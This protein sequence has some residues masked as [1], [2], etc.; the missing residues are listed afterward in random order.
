MQNLKRIKARLNES[1]TFLKWYFLGLGSRDQKIPPGQITL[2]EQDIS[3]DLLIIQ[4][5]EGEGPDFIKVMPE[6]KEEIFIFYITPY[7]TWV[8][9]KINNN[10]EC[11]TIILYHPTFMEDII[12]AL[13][14]LLKRKISKFVLIIEYLSML[15][16]KKTGEDLDLSEKYRVH[17]KNYKRLLLALKQRQQYGNYSLVFID[18]E[19]NLSKKNSALLRR[20]FST[21]IEQ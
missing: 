11:L 6:M 17:E 20:L 10:H 8:P 15:S 7:L 16:H 1:I 12:A 9:D 4:S 5:K 14:E 19:M 18:N 2:N 21:K 13:D 3:Q